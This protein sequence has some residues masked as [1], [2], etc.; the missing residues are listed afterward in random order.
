[1]QT[2]R[3]ENV[4]IFSSDDWSSGL[5]TSKY[6]LARQLA[7][8]NRVLFVNSIGLRSPGANRRDLGR[9]FSKLGAFL[10][11]ARRVPE[12]LHV[13]TPIAIPFKRNHPLVRALNGMLLR[14]S[15]RWLKLRLGLGHP[16]VFVFIPTFNDVVGRLGE[17]AILYYCIDDLRG[18]AGVDPD[19]FN[20]REDELLAR[21]DAVISS[22]RELNEAFLRKGAPAHYVPHGVDWPL[23]R[24]AVVE[25]L[26]EPEDLR[27]IPH[28]RFGF[29]GFLS[30]EWVD[31]PLLNR[32]ASE[33]PDWHIVLIGRPRAGMEMGSLITAPN[34]HYLGLKPFEELP[35]YTRHFDVG[36]IPFCRNELTRHSNP[37]KLLEYLA[38]GLP[39]VSTDI[40]EV[41]Q[42]GEQVRVAGSP[43]AFIAACE[44][45]LAENSPEQREKRS[46]FAEAH[47]W[48][49]RMETISDIAHDCIIKR[50]KT[51]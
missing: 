49:R 28:P 32:M 5:K 6:H 38:G 11:G 31:Y 30:D 15:L 10:R 17:K 23:F 40:P 36:L 34:L 8:G 26:P 47:S 45:A 22:A 37:L 12:G 16:I 2:L 21:S 35:A 50:N 1:M 20:R 7:R 51:L 27:G 13:Y 19:W 43:E 9:I 33:R 25:P 39:A 42:Y 46:R 29:Y 3:N 44:K 18:Y 41:R 14:N 48:E 24:R 4:I